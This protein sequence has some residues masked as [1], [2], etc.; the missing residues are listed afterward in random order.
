MPR[1]HSLFVTNRKFDF[2]LS[3]FCFK[4]FIKLLFRTGIG[5]VKYIM[6]FS[7]QVLL[8]SGSLLM[9]KSRLFHIVE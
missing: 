4:L 2:C 8:A 3:F 1:L 7:I 5:D 9:I 6:L